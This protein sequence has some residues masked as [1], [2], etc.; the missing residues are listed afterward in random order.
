MSIQSVI[1]DLL[2]TKWIVIGYS[3]SN[4]NMSADVCAYVC[5]TSGVESVGWEDAIHTNDPGL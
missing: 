3:Y 1:S 5:R 2:H 4:Q